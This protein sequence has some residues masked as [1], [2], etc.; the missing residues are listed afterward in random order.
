M[1]AYI[2][3]TLP[4]GK[5]TLQVTLIKLGNDSF[6]TRLSLDFFVVFTP[7][8]TVSMSSPSSFT[9]TS[10]N[11]TTSTSVISNF[12]IAHGNGTIT[13]TPSFLATTSGSSAL[14][15]SGASSSPSPSS[16][17]ERGEPSQI[18]LII[19]PIF[20][21]IGVCGIIYLLLRR[22]RKQKDLDSRMIP[23]S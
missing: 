1:G 2:S 10:T 23:A 5:H 6:Y 16:A 22:R 12:T 14:S 18:P 15:R 3:P 8:D 20:G 9:T 21:V 13:L 17:I 19:G 11:A 4:N 7:D